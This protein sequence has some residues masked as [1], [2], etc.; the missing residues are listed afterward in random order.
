M[1]PAKKNERSDGGLG[2]CCWFSV[3]FVKFWDQ[4]HSKFN[5]KV[6]IS[7]VNTVKLDILSQVSVFGGCLLDYSMTTAPQTKTNLSRTHPFSDRAARENS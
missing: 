2:L 3:V 4:W 7:I 6:S 1:W 5:T